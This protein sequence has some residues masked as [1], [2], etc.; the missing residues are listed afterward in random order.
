M[1]SGDIK[2]ISKT[3]ILVSKVYPSRLVT[4]TKD[5]RT[6]KYKNP[7][8]QPLQLTIYSNQV[9]L[10]STPVDAHGIS[11]T[12]M[13]IPFPLRKDIKNRVKVLNSK[14]E[15]LFDDVNCLFTDADNILPPIYNVGSY[16]VQV[17]NSY[18]ALAGLNISDELYKKIG[19][20]YSRGYGFLLCVLQLSAKYQPLMFI[21]ELKQDNKLFVPTRHF[22]CNKTSKYL[23]VNVFSEY[24]DNTNLN[25]VESYHHDILMLG[26]KYIRHHIGRNHT[27]EN[28]I[29]NWD[30]RIYVVN[31][32]IPKSRIG[33]KSEIPRNE[34]T[35]N[36]S[37][38]INLNN[39]PTNLTFGGIKRI[40]RI[41]IDNTYDRNCDLFI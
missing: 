35:R 41:T 4:A 9:E 8:G 16:K 25:E 5:G 37:E 22:C 21:H 15:G 20:Y 31:S 2:E 7:D 39:F 10:S 32:D 1:F 26:D 27:T 30:H 28:G 11:N 33:F 3:N 6:H 34:K 14:Y 29:V 23:G 13:I 19:S 24:G 38:Y 18:T 40:S 12:F 36:I 17:L